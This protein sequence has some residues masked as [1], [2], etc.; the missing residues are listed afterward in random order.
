MKI[1]FTAEGTHWDSRM[2]ARFGRT[3]YILIYD[4][5]TNELTVIDNHENTE[6]AH[7]AGPQTAQKLFKIAPDILITGNSPGGN[8]ATV[9]KKTNVK[10]YIGAGEFSIEEAY[11]AYQKGELKEF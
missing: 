3:A 7:G 9:L 1:A 6:A 10:I 5:V 4:D 8:A 11:R 2:D